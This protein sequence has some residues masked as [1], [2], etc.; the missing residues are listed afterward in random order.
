MGEDRIARQ[1][2]LQ[3]KADECRRAKEEQVTK[4]KKLQGELQAALKKMPKR[5]RESIKE[6]DGKIEYVALVG[7]FAVVFGGGG[8]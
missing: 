5:P 7:M 1:E 6:L 3:K 4:I 8:W 2:R